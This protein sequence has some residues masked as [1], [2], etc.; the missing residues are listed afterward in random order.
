MQQINKQKLMLLFE[1]AGKSDP[2]AHLLY[3]ASF[4]KGLQWQYNQ[5]EIVTFDDIHSFDAKWFSSGTQAGS[6]LMLPATWSSTGAASN[7]QQK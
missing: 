7:L 1:H 6:T 3:K 5:V 4:Y 2:N